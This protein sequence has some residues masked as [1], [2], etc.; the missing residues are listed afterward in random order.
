MKGMCHIWSSGRH[1]SPSLPDVLRGDRYL[2]S[3]THT[4]SDHR[5]EISGNDALFAH[6]QHL[7]YSGKSCPETMSN[8]H[9]KFL[10]SFPVLIWCAG[11]SLEQEMRGVFSTFWGHGE[12]RY[13]ILHSLVIKRPVISLSWFFVGGG[14]KKNVFTT[15]PYLLTLISVQV[16]AAFQLR[17]SKSVRQPNAFY[18]RLKKTMDVFFFFLYL[19]KRR[20]KNRN[21]S[22]NWW[23]L[24]RGD[25]STPWWK[26]ST[27][28]GPLTCNIRLNAPS[29]ADATFKIRRLY[30]LQFWSLSVDMSGKIDKRI[31]CKKSNPAGEILATRQSNP[32]SEL[33]ACFPPSK[34][35]LIIAFLTI[36]LMTVSNQSGVLMVSE[37]NTFF[38]MFISKWDRYA[39]DRDRQVIGVWVKNQS[40]K[41]K[42]QK[43]TYSVS[44][45]YWQT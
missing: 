45:K 17:N 21:S 41:V 25:S 42:Q 13:V 37:A 29:P 27:F 8:K 31:P 20:T 16:R 44:P 9:E 12:E 15:A 1:F 18:L 19:E 32:M 4:K 28:T 26:E 3:G 10:K 34:L 14:V 22:H 35:L 5:A 39:S 33:V 30:F 24:A 40:S 11:V 38:F 6:A 43:Q 36:F 23:R 2:K 7:Q